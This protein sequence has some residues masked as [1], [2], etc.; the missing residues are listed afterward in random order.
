MFCHELEGLLVGADTVK[1][2]TVAGVTGVNDNPVGN[3]E[4][5]QSLAD[6][7]HILFNDGT[8]FIGGG[9]ADDLS[10]SS[11]LMMQ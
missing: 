11:S 5:L 2:E 3:A 7:G 8:V 9:D 4:I 10:T 1:G 6:L